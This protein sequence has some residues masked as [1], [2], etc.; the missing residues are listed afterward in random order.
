[1]CEAFFVKRTK[2]FPLRDGAALIQRYSK[3][4]QKP[5]DTIYKAASIDVPRSRQALR[6]RARAAFSRDGVKAVF[7]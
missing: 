4:A 3:G 6:E 7:L 5:G 1:L 2:G